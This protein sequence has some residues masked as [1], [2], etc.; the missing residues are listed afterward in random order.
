MSSL[1]EKHEPIEF[2]GD[3]VVLVDRVAGRAQRGHP[4]QEILV[5]QSCQERVGAQRRFF[6]EARPICGGNLRHNS[7]HDRRK[8][9]QN[10]GRPDVPP[11]REIGRDQRLKRREKCRCGK[12]DSRVPLRMQT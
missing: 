11:R 5:G 3:G 2:F 4:M 8:A 9:A 10:K 6:D 7:V 1:P 12:S